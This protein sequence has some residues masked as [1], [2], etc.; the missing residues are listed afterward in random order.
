[1]S[2]ITVREF[3][4]YSGMVAMTMTAMIAQ[5]VPWIRRQKL[6]VSASRARPNIAEG[7]R[8]AVSLSPNAARESATALK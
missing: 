6:Y 4:T 1:M 3:T 7:S 8:A 5:R 2:K